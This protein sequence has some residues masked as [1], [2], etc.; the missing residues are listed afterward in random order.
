LRA[1]EADDH[2]LQHANSH[3]R[4]TG[5]TLPKDIAYFQTSSPTSRRL[6]TIQSGKKAPRPAD[7]AVSDFVC[8]PTLLLP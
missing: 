2:A 7:A 3:S 5:A 8:S 4:K 6:G 1:V